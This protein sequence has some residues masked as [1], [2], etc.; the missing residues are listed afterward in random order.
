MLSNRLVGLSIFIKITYGIVF[1]INIFQYVL[2]RDLYTNFL[3]VMLFSVIKALHNFL[4][5]K[6]T[7]YTN[8]KKMYFIEI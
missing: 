4:L 7:S 5:L 3:D 6:K 1:F 2:A 8:S